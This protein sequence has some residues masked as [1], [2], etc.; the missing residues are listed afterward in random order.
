MMGVEGRTATEPGGRPPA[1]R[2]LRRLQEFINTYNIERNHL[3]LRREEF[4]TPGDLR[5]WLQARGLLRG[6][7]EVTAADVH[8]AVRVREALRRLLLAHNRQ[9]PAAH[10]I[11]ALNRLA[12]AARLVIQ[13]R[14]DGT[15][16]IEAESGGAG[17][18]LGRLLASAFA[19]QLDGT[20]ERLKA[21]RRCHWAFYDQSRNRSGRWCAMS[22]CGNRMKARRYRTHRRTGSSRRGAVSARA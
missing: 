17:G 9:R 7:A 4:S 12:R 8:L 13:F 15:V 14:P 16:E 6:R 11:A 20:W 3:G 22:I 1:P 19:A 18:A 21:C 5:R 10:E 2:N